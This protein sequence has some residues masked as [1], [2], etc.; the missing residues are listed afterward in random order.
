M[1]ST[2][3]IVVAVLSSRVATVVVVVVMMLSRQRGN[4]EEHHAQC[5]NEG[6][7]SFPH[8]YLHQVDSV[9]TLH[10]PNIGLAA[11]GTFEAGSPDNVEQHAPCEGQ[12]SL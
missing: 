11:C 5:C 7:C 8:D 3:S 10:N 1:V 6:R 4:R 9:V 12:L 2:I